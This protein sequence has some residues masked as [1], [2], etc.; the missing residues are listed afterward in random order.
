MNLTNLTLRFSPRRCHATRVAPL[1]PIRKMCVTRCRSQNMARSFTIHGKLIPSAVFTN[2]FCS[3]LPLR[4]YGTTELRSTTP[5]IATCW[6]LCPSQTPVNPAR[7][8]AVDISFGSM[9]IHS[10]NHQS[11]GAVDAWALISSREEDFKNVVC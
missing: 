5:L 7:P 2:P 9:A 4:D 3:D 8:N 1:P 6:T 10:S 11:V